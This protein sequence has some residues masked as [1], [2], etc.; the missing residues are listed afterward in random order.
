MDI[1]VLI[2]FTHSWASNASCGRYTYVSITEHEICEVIS[3][4]FP[5]TMHL[6]CWVMRRGS[7]AM[8][9]SADQNSKANRHYIIIIRTVLN[10]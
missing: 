4:V 9:L 10:G 2:V 1:S 8:D 6:L 5:Y 7:S 3:F